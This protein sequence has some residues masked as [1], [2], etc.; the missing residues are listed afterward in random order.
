MTEFGIK[1]NPQRRYHP[2]KLLENAMS[3]LFR[4]LQPWQGARDVTLLSAPFTATPALVSG[5]GGCPL[6]S[7]SWVHLPLC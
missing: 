4:W 6:I 5:A 2:L 7:W 3:V 1:I